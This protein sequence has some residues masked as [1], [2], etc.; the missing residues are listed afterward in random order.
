MPVPGPQG[1]AGWQT[2]GFGWQT[3]FGWQVVRVR[4]LVRVRE[5]QPDPPDTKAISCIASSR[6]L[7]LLYINNFTKK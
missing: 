1:G 3:G 2:G 4:Q 5:P 7:I 6:I